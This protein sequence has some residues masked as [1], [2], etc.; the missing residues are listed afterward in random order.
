HFRDPEHPEWWGYLNRQGEVLL[1][2]KG[3][4]WKGCFHVPRGLYQVWKTMEKIDKI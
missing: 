1:D 4:K 2:L 3:G